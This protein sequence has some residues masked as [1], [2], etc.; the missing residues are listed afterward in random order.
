MS[1]SA[2]SSGK[3]RLI[4]DLR[5]VN[6]FVSTSKIKFDDAQSMLNVFIG[7][8]PSNL[9]AYSLDIKSGYHH[10]EI[11]P[12]HQRFLG[13]S[14]VFNGV[15][16]YFKSFVLPFGLSTGPYIFTKVMRPLVKHW[17]FQAL[18]IVVYLDDGLVVCGT[19]DDCLRHSL[20]VYSDLI[21]SGFV[22]NKDKCMWIYVQFLRW[23]GFY[24][25][26]ARGLLSIPEDKISL[27]LASISEVPSSRIAIAR[28]LAQVTGSIISC[29]LVFG[30]ICRHIVKY[31]LDL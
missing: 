6:F 26:F 25:D 24:W 11:Y 31:G 27:L 23:L 19:K 29:M 7:E 18:R 3:K 9:W 14:W 17:R 28:M 8:F 15:R 2:Q 20:S 10:V 22:P 1:V 4:V 5:P 12:S 30:Y 13:F 16:R 21:S